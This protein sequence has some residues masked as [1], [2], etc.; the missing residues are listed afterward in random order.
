MPYPIERKLVIDVS[1]SALFDLSESDSVFRE[2]GPKAYSEYQE[3]HLDMVPGKGVAF[4]FMRR[5]LSIRD[6]LQQEQPVE[7]VLLSRNSAIAGRRGFR[8]IKVIT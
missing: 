6:R 8:S 3:K 4:P 5:F 2:E 1:L 7:V